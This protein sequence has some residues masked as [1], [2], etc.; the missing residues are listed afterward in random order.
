ML[1]QSKEL[2]LQ[3]SSTVAC[4]AITLGNVGVLILTQDGLLMRRPVVRALLIINVNRQDSPAEREGKSGLK[5]IIYIIHF[6]NFLY[7]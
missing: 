6:R 7:A 3:T 2:Q 5:E 4:L 1:L